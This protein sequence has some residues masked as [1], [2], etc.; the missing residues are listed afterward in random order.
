MVAELG[1]I[2]GGCKPSLSSEWWGV[3]HGTDG[4]KP[5]RTAEGD[6]NLEG[7]E[8][9][10]QNFDSGVKFRNTRAYANTALTAWG[11]DGSNGTGG[12]K[13]R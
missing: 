7:L 3:Q 2:C 10:H 9:I 5:D 4:D 12:R 11:T 6:P 1:R 13:M 8:E